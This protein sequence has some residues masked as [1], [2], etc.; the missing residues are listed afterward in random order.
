[1]MAE[2][3][4]DGDAGERR[5]RTQRRRYVTILGWVFG[6]S[7]LLGAGGR[8]IAE[9][10]S[11]DSGGGLSL[12]PVAAIALVGAF[13]VIVGIGSWLYFRAID[14]LELEANKW[15]GVIGIN[16][17]AVAFPVWWVLAIAKLTPPPD[18]WTV[19]GATIAVT[20]LAFLWRRLR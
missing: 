16:F 19:Y 3:L 11:R 18:E 13:L 10:W 20:L 6:I 2:G 8:I 9:V 12:P 4:M 7:L 1:M 17:Y 14:E 15:A 5:L